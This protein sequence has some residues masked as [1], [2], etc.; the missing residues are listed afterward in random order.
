MFRILIQRLVP[1]FFQTKSI[2]SLPPTPSTRLLC[3]EIELPLSP[4]VKDRDPVGAEL[5]SG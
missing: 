4:P 5:S 3:P 1:R 2:S